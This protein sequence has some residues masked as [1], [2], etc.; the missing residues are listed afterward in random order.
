MILQIS[1]GQGPVECELAVR[2][3]FESLQR[4]FANYGFEQKTSTGKIR[5]GIKKS[6]F[7]RKIKTECRS[8]EFQ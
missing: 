1:S 7:S 6:C 5:S 4:E 8:M 3:L 2:L